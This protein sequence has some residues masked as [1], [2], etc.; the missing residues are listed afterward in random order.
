MEPYTENPVDDENG[1][2][3]LAEAIVRRAANDY[4]S[5]LRR[6]RSRRNAAR[7]REITGFFRSDYFYRLTGADGEQMLEVIRKEAERK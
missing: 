2:R 3:L 6:R 4:L 7:M 1:F 5:A